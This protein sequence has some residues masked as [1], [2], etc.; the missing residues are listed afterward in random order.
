MR[1]RFDGVQVFVEAVEAGGFARAAERLALSRSAV[2]KSIARLEERLGVRLFHRTTRTQSLTE[3][4]QQYYERCLRA[5]DE[6]RAAQ[7]L[8]ESGRREVVGRLRVSL[9]VLSAMARAT[10]PAIPP[11][12]STVPIPRRSTSA[13]EPS[14][15]MAPSATTPMLKRRP[16][17]SRWRIL[18]HT[19]SM[20]NGISG[21]R[22]TSALPEIPLLSAMNPAWNTGKMNRCSF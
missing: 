18:A 1:D 7:S 17:A 6:L 21:S 5:I 19:F 8:L 22:M 10:R 13:T 14:I 9:P 16:A 3:D 15:G 2:G 12:R 4:G 20:S 11:S